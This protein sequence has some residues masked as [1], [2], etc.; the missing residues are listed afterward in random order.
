ML[1]ISSFIHVL[2]FDSYRRMDLRRQDAI[3]HYVLA[4]CKWALISH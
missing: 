3:I 1:W 2:S 4:L